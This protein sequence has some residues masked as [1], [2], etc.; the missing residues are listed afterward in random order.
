MSTSAHTFNLLN[1]FVG[2][3]RGIAH[4]IVVNKSVT[5]KKTILTNPSLIIAWRASK[6]S[7]GSVFRPTESQITPLFFIFWARH[8]SATLKRCAS[9]QII[10]GAQCS[11]PDK[12]MA[13]SCNMVYSPYQVKNYLGKYWQDNGYSRVP[14]P[15]TIITGNIF[16]FSDNITYLFIK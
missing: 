9:L 6:A 12:R 14:E 5:C 13:V 10:N 15:P 3:K 4:F 16:Y 1:P 8:W 7:A 2:V 11:I